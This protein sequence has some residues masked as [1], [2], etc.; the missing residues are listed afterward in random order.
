MAR[1]RGHSDEALSIFERVGALPLGGSLEDGPLSSA[2][3]KSTR[4]VAG[5]PAVKRDL[6]AA[7][8]TEALD[9]LLA[10]GRHQEVRALSRV[11]E[12]HDGPALDAIRREANACALARLGLREESMTAL[13][14]A[15]D[16]EPP[17]RRPVFVMKRAELLAAFGSVEAARKIALAVGASLT[18]RLHERPATLSELLLIARV[19]RLL[20]G[21]G[22]TEAAAIAF[23][24][25]PHARAV[26]DVPLEVELALRV[27]DGEDAAAR[28]EAR[29]LLREL[30]VQSG[31]CLPAA[32]DALAREGDVPVPENAGAYAAFACLCGALEAL[33]A[34]GR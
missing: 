6:A 23:L 29:A 16:C 21:L 10:A 25:L 24:A 1:D 5:A 19:C 33:G 32:A 9:T 31:H 2:D 18:S 12:P 13:A 7:V 22:D 15:L 34:G 27:L 20:A 17:E 4:L 11:R 14:E 3:P 8:V 26:G 30:V 28:D